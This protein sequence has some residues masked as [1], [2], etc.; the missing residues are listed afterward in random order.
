MVLEKSLKDTTMRPVL[1]MCSS[2]SYNI[3]SKL[4]KWLSVIPETSMN[5][6]T[7]DISQ[8]IENMKLEENECCISFDILGLHTKVQWN[9]FGAEN[10]EF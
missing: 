2:M 3:A 5:Q 4:A 6:N 8:S 9:T 10:V 1:S 7:A